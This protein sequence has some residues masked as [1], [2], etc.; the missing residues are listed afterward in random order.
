[1]AS[2]IK[3]RRDTAANWNFV[4]PV[5]SAGE[6][7]LEL[8]TGNVK[9]GDGTSLWTN[10]PYLSFTN[11][12]NVIGGI[13]S[14]TSLDVSEGSV[15]ISSGIVTSTV[16]IVT[17]YG[18]GSKLSGIGSNL[19]YY[20]AGV[21]PIASQVAITTYNAEN[22]RVFTQESTLTLSTWTVNIQNLNL[23]NDQATTIRIIGSAG[24][25]VDVN[26]TGIQID[27]TSSGVVTYGFPMKTTKNKTGIHMITIVKDSSGSNYNVYGENSTL[28]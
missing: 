11:A 27:G 4:N 6:P 3:I 17:Y 25:A 19:T 28:Y 24:G 22:S 7:G 18:D 12:V 14:V 15:N 5:L 20:N 16:G 10:L 2:K 26:L 13:A 8:D 1:M 9:Y 23:Q 21:L